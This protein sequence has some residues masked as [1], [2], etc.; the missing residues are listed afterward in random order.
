MGSESEAGSG[1]EWKANFPLTVCLSTALCL[2]V[3]G[4]GNWDQ[5]EK[6]QRALGLVMAHLE[7]LIGAT[8]NTVVPAPQ[9]PLPGAGAGAGTEVMKGVEIGTETETETGTETK[10]GIETESETG[11]GT[12]T[13][14]EN[15]TGTESESGRALSAVS[16]L[17]Q[18]WVAPAKQRVRG[19]AVT[20]VPNSQGQT[21]SPKGG[22][23]A[24]G[25]HC[26]CM[27]RT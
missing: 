7:A 23:L 25:T 3:I 2:L 11:T 4:F 8:R 27:E 18:G 19:S 12:G 20:V 5:M 17:G 9:L 14:T 21:P 10:I 24:R 16:G 26:M 22:P 13:E 15:E 1:L 6:K